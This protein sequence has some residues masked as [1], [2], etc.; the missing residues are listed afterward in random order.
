MN[1]EVMNRQMF[2]QGGF[3]RP[4]QEGGIA[5][6]QLMPQ[7]APAPDPAM[8]G[9]M[10]PDPAMMGGMPPEEMSM[11]QA[12]QG[13]MAQGVDPAMLEQTLGDYQQGMN[14]LDNAE[15]YETV[16]NTIRGDQ[17]PMQARY[18]ELAG[19]VGPEDAT[20]TPESVLTLIQPV[21]QM[22]AVDQGI[23]GLAQDEMMAPI[24]G[25]MAEG[26]MSTVNMGPAEGPAPVNF[27]QG[28]A[29]QYMD[30][31]G[32]VQYMAKG[33]VD[34]NSANLAF[35]Q[36][37]SAKNAPIAPLSTYPSLDDNFASA[38]ERYRTVAGP[39]AY[40]EEDLAQEKDLTKA[41]MYFDLAAAGL[42]FAAPG[43]RQMSAAE[44][45]ASAA[46]DT[47]LFEKI[48]ARAKEQ[49]TAEMARKTAMRAENM[50]LD[51]AAMGSAETLTAAQAKARS[52]LATMKKPEIKTKN[53][54]IMGK[55]NSMESVPLGGSRYNTMMADPDNNWV[56]AETYKIP[57]KKVEYVN[58]M[59]LS[60]PENVLSFRVGSK[61][62]ESHLGKAG[63][64]KTGDASQARSEKGKS[65]IQQFIVPIEGGGTRIVPTIVDS[66]KFKDFVAAEY[67]I[68]GS[69]SIADTKKATKNF[70]NAKE[71]KIV[72]VYADSK[73]ERKY[74]GLADWAETGMASQTVSAVGTTNWVNR[75]SGDV[76]TT[77]NNSTRF[78]E[79]LN[80][81]DWAKTDSKKQVDA[82]YSIQNFIVPNADGK[83]NK[84]V[85]YF[86]GSE[87][88]IDAVAKGY[89]PTGDA[90]Q[91]D[92]VA[93]ILTFENEKGEITTVRD[94]DTAAID[95]LIENNAWQ[96]TTQ[97]VSKEPKAPSSIRILNKQ[98]TLDDYA[99]GTLTGDALNEFEALALASQEPT[100]RI[101]NGQTIIT[102]GPPFTRAFVEAYQARVAAGHATS[103]IPMPEIPATVS[104]AVMQLTEAEK[105]FGVNS[106]ESYQIL[107]NSVDPRTG[108]ASQGLLL[109]PEFNKMLLNSSGTVDLNSPAWSAVPTTIFNFGVD[110]DLAQGLGTAV[111]RLVAG[112]REI[113]AQFGGDR[114]NSDSQMLYQADN[115]FGLLKMN[116]V[117][118]LQAGLRD[119][120]ILKRTNDM[121]FNYLKPLDPGIMKFDSF[122]LAAMES[123][124]KQ[125]AVDLNTHVAILAEYGA[126]PAAI[127]QASD[128][129]IR[130]SVTS[131]KELRSLIAEFTKFSTSLRAALDESVKMI[132][133][134][135]VR[136]NSPTSQNKKNFIYNLANPAP[137]Q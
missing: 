103:N 110:Y 62:A 34:Q 30:N 75:E 76:Q 35:A 101:E 38:R 73:D 1:R 49:Q 117:A 91:S 135:V 33:G 112:F 65:T 61:E 64:A 102:P 116:T 2:A 25:P 82:S 21:M 29:V 105:D 66:Q 84:V 89:L 26:I 133:G 69:S 74:I 85:P 5:S 6:M 96:I 114:M 113:A 92:R 70:F 59:E 126:D 48:G 95:N 54:M 60:N 51:L 55:P 120:R 121:I 137:T 28:G 63:W 131:A 106:K 14:D 87:N 16:I 4:M 124:R 78:E 88:Y 37:L 94:D 125:L 99:N 7:A 52:D 13:A 80:S 108:A 12:A 104:Q 18:D 9:G 20:A 19:M 46:R 11:D 57:D 47:Q 36:S 24:E 3:V 97:G 122:T 42:A 132:D 41:Q 39:S 118:K 134:Q 27:S 130:K 56:E 45:L 8:M 10:P 68:T 90:T 77:R 81:E 123:I 71:N 79:Y 40:T 109:T 86:V 136:D 22:A 127:A 107:S 43:D 17:L 100:K 93:N 31:G 50:Q 98:S 44:N 119:G 32:P 72:T 53:F 58:F 83:G 15:D 115:D 23:G 111:P 129:K 67:E 128:E